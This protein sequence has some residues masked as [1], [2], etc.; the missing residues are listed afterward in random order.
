M[1]AGDAHLCDYF[2]MKVMLA[3]ALLAL[4]L[5]AFAAENS[6]IAAIRAAVPS[7]KT[8]DTTSYG[9]RV[10]TGSGTVFVNK[11]SYGYR[12]EGGKNSAFITKTPSGYRITSR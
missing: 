8:I 6:A 2:A 7:A 10:Q 3:I 9:Y 1:I 4:S 11:T 12:I 5:P